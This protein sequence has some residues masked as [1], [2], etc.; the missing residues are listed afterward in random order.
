MMSQGAKGRLCHHLGGERLS[1]PLIGCLQIRNLGVISLSFY[2]CHLA[3]L[4]PLDTS[5][6]KCVN[7]LLLKT[8]TL[9]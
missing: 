9:P 3:K 6:P 7:H 5:N 4:S 8:S 1:L 2:F